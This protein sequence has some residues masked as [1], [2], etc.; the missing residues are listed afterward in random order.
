[1]PIGYMLQWS[2]PFPLA[3]YKQ[4]PRGPGIYIIGRSITV[5]PHPTQQTEDDPY[6]GRWPESFSPFYVGISEAKGAG[7]RERLSRH[8]RGKGNRRVADYLKQ[9]G[10]LWFITVPGIEHI[11]SEALLLCLQTR[12]QFDAN[13]RREVERSMKRQAARVQNAMTAQEREYYDHLDM[14]EHDEGM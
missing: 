10:K 2:D 6:L 7:V 12:G 9:G 14:G 5:D 3:D 8:Y 1:M 11:E 4:A 13:I